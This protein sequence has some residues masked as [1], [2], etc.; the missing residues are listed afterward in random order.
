VA[1]AAVV[2]VVSS[3][4][5]RRRKRNNSY[6]FQIIPMNNIMKALYYRM[7]S[8]WLTLFKSYSSSSSSSSS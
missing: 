1:K 5:S 8:C 2:V 7:A 3:S 4:S 6:G